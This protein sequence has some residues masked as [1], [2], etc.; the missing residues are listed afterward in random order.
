MHDQ[1]G[2][3]VALT[4]SSGAVSGG[5]SYT[6]YGAVL[7]HTGTASTPIQYGDGYTDAETG[8]IYLHARYY[9]P[10]TAQFLTIDPQLASTNEPYA[11]V[12][13]NP[14]NLIDPL[15]A[16]G[17]NPLHW[18]KKNWATV[19]LIAGG[20]ALAA[21]GVG[22]VAD[23]G[24]GGGL[25]ASETFVSTVGYVG[26]GAGALATATDAVPCFRSFGSSEGVDAGACTGA[27]LGSLSLG[28]GAPGVF[29]KIA[30]DGL[31][32]G[33]DVLSG[34]YGA[35]G[36]TLDSGLYYQEYYGPEA[37][38]E[39]KKE[40]FSSRGGAFGNGATEGWGCGE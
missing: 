1:L 12:N 13:D 30:D 29:G 16:W 40:A 6:S 8:L 32:A 23:L 31:H 4:N 21:T 25:L 17:W 5:Y 7:T 10:A 28:I 39:R 35:A 15:G 36:L 38:Q 27:A 34:T 14:L 24:I 11:Y 19:G 37:E 20:V 3:T 18:S 33:L 26:F 2:S 22:A 9:D